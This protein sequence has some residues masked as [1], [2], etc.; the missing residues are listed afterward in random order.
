MTIWQS[1]YYPPQLRLDAPD[2]TND[3]RA[4]KFNPLPKSNLARPASAP[5]QGHRDSS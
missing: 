1:L 4:Y 2:W 3:K 5:E